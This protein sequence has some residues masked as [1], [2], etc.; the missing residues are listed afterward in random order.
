MVE[1]QEILKLPWLNESELYKCVHCGF[2][3]QACPTY[4]TTGL[5]TE[6]PRGRIAL[7]KAVNEGR[8]EISDQVMRHWDLCIQCR[9]C[10]DVC[11]SGVPYGNLIESTM[12][13]IRDHRKIGFIPRLAYEISLRHLIPNQR[14]LAIVVSMMNLYVKS[15]LQKVVRKTKILKLISKRFE[16]LEKMT[17][18]VNGKFFRAEGQLYTADVEGTE[19]IQML[20]GCVMP[21]TQGNQMRAAVRTL[22]KANKDVEVPLNQGCCGAINSHVGDLGK[23][24]ELAR[25]NIEA[26][27]KGSGTE[28]IIV[29]SAGCGARMREYGHLLSDDPDYASKAVDFSKRVVD[30]NEYLDQAKLQPG[31]T[32]IPKTVT[33]QDSCHLANVQKVKDAPRNLIKSIDGIDFCELKGSY[34]CCGAGGTYMITE[35]EMA[36]AVLAEKIRNL[37]DSGADIIATANPG[38]FMQLDNGIK[39]A[40]INVEVKYVTDLLDETYT[41]SK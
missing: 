22:N 6:S 20:S 36:E 29:N 17:P 18:A 35:P 1:A 9:A 37:V 4:L 21:L 3:L 2:C 25:A 26:F 8:L 10:E 7:M 14:N 23:A 13:Q 15:G 40:G 27:S 34:I 31:E 16:R 32:S 19:T 11:P 33:Y 30:I 28:P 39:A 38:C 24:K 5:E 41:K 12:D